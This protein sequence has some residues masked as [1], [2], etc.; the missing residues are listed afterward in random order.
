[1]EADMA[2]ALPENG[3]KPKLG[4][5]FWLLWAAGMVVINAGFFGVIQWNMAQE[6]WFNLIG[7]VTAEI[8]TV[9]LFALLMTPYVVGRKRGV[10][11]RMRPPIR[12]YLTRFMPAMLGYV[13][14]LMPA[15]ALF[16]EI[17]PTGALAWAIAVAP[18][19]PLLFAIRAITLYYKEEDDEFVR[20]M[21]V[22]SHLHAF[23]LTMAIATVY[24]FLDLFS[25]VPHIQAWAI[26]P[27]WAVCLMPAQVA[28]QWKFR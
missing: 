27:L 20:A 9:A 8:Y 19:I 25:L 4:M 11:P 18:A 3:S 13:L 24:G 7:T 6:R 28:A 10:A 16:Q 14:L 26:V 21:A 17:K 2:E 23:G 15:M 22:Q 1:M 5:G 12:R